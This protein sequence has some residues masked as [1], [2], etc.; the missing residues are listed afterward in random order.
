MSD[1]SGRFYFKEL[2]LQQFRALEH[3]ARAEGFAGAGEALGLSRSTV[4]R[5]IRTL[6]RELK[7]ELVRLRGRNVEITPAGRLLLELII[8]VL[9]DFAHIVPEFQRRLQQGQRS[10]V[11]VA[12]QQLLIYE[13]PPAIEQLREEHPWLNLRLFSEPSSVCL[14]MLQRDEADIAIVGHLDPLHH[15]VSLSCFPITTYDTVVLCPA[16]HWLA[17][18]KKWTVKDIAAC[19]LI[20]P[21]QRTSSRSRFESA[22]ARH[23]LLDQLNVVLESN[24]LTSVMPYVRRGFAIAFYTIS[25][26]HLDELRVMH[27]RGEIAYRAVS[28]LFGDETVYFATKKSRAGLPHVEDFRRILSARMDVRPRRQ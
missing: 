24:T 28:D 9:A 2:R 14:E 7:S 27:E 17:R 26:H 16:D 18:K 8:P 22:F 5:Q 12:P 15:D 3:L 21:T 1:T 6:E 25:H 13:F 19:P 4:W 23:G 11:V 10:M 20:M